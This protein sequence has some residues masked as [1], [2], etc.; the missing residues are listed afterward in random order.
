[1]TASPVVSNH[2]KTLAC[3]ATGATGAEVVESVQSL[4]SGYGEI[5]RVSLT[6]SDT[7][8]L[9][10]KH[11]AP[12]LDSH[13]PRGWH[14]DFATQR[15]LKSYQ[16]ESAWYRHWS[17]QCTG[18]CR[19]PI[20]YGADQQG[21]QSWLLLEDL[22][23]AGYAIRHSRLNASQAAD[24]LRWLAGFHATFLKTQATGLWT[25]G[26]YWHLD[27]RPD[28]FKAMP[29]GP[30]RDHAAHVDELLNNC[31]FKTLVHGDAKVANFCF[32]EGSAVAA[33]DFQ[34]TGAGCG[35]KDV[36]YF[37]GS[38]FDESD[39]EKYAQTLLD[40]YFDELRKAL[41]KYRGEIK[42]FDSLE[43]EWRSL[44]PVAWTDFHRFLSGWMPTHQKIHR[45][46]EKMTDITL[47]RIV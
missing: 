5:F 21:H 38:C 35:M 29:A 44:Y 2:W 32:S 28:E 26:T 43:H 47:Q 7:Q 33:V 23:A 12:P 36:A 19:V 39:C 31:R 25:I 13:H 16:V 9:I 20:C 41:Q 8:S 46:T 40:G 24:C 22:D 3:Q 37:I 45:Y 30:L 18:H 34:Y 15:K 6:G 17:K 4:W 14:S 42:E 11:V 1:M 27:T 10:I